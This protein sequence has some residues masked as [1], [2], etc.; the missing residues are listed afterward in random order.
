MLTVDVQEGTTFDICHTGT[1]INV[2]QVASMQS[3]FGTAANLTFVTATIDI[4]TN[5]NLSMGL[6]T[7]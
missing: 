2:V 7:C 6:S 3:N 4:T 5:R 1:A